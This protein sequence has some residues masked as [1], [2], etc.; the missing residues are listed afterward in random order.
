MTTRFPYSAELDKTLLRLF[1]DDNS[2]WDLAARD[3]VRHDVA[4]WLNRQADTELFYLLSQPQKGMSLA[5]IVADS[6]HA[7]TFGQ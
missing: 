7:I 5:H 6:K 4:D 3:K 2:V 1:P